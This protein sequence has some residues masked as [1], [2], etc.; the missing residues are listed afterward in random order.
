MCEAVLLAGLTPAHGAGIAILYRLGTSLGDS[1]GF[2]VGFIAEKAAAQWRS[3]ARCVAATTV[4]IDEGFAR[5]S[6]TM[7]ILAEDV[8]TLS[9]NPD[10]NSRIGKPLVRPRQLDGY[11]VDKSFDAGVQ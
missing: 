6:N 1:I 7:P 9:I 8:D 4:E 3:A 11:Q 2:V 10:T 5:T